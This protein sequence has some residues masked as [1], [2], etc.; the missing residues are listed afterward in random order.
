[1]RRAGCQGKLELVFFMS[2][3]V[4]EGTPRGSQEDLVCGHESQ[5]RSS[6]QPQVGV[7]SHRED[8]CPE[9]EDVCAA[10]ASNATGRDAGG[11]DGEDGRRDHPVAEGAV[12]RRVSVELVDVFFRVSS[13]FCVFSASESDKKIQEILSKIL[14]GNVVSSLR[15][16]ELIHLS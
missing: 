7:E 4:F 2:G 9:V 14:E 16:S 5:A 13:A 12:G 10:L 15:E 1:M 11:A 8:G 3:S 6:Q